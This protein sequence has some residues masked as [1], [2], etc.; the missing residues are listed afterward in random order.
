MKEIR[1]LAEVAALAA[2]GTAE[3]TVRQIA[4]SLR[5]VIAAFHDAGSEWDP[6]DHGHFV[7]L[8][9]GDDVRDLPE[10]HLHP[11]NDGLVGIPKEVVHRHAAAGLWEIVVIFNDGGYGLTYLVPDEPWLDGDLRAA[12]EAEVGQPGPSPPFPAGA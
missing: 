4:D 8:E 6:F 12:L 1:S 10:A 5:R 11:W 2:G 9:A 3:V 7:L